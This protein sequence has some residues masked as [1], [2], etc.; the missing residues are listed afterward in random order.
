MNFMYNLVT[1]GKKII[2]YTVLIMLLCIILYY[3]D[4]YGSI[5]YEAYN[6]FSIFTQIITIALGF[7]L[8]LIALSSANMCNYNYFHFLAIIVGMIGVIDLF[9]ILIYKGANSL[10][11]D[12]NILFQ[13]NTLCRC[14][15]CIT[16]NLSIICYRKK[17]DFY[18]ILMINVAFVSLFLLSITVFKIFPAC[19]IEGYGL[20]SFVKVT[21]YLII[22]GFIIMLFQVNSSNAP[23]F[24]ENRE[25]IIK[26]VIF[27]VLESISF[28][29][30]ISTYS[31]AN[32]LGYVFKGLSC[33]FAFKLIFK[34]IMLNPYSILVQKLN[35]KVNELKT[36]N[37]ELLEAKYKI[38]SKENLHSR[39]INFIPDGV[40]IAR[41]KHIEFANDR[42]L[43]MLE[44][45]DINKILNRE[46]SEIID[47]KQREI[48]RARFN[49]VD[50]KILEIPQQYK[51]VFDGKEKWVEVTSIT[52]NDEKGE[53]IISTIRDI[54]DRKKAE[55]TERL[56]ELKKSEESMK[57][58][59]FCNISHEL[60]TPINVIYSA[61][62]V[63]NNALKNGESND[64][65]IKYNKIIRQNCLRLTR[66]VNNIID[67][68]K[69]ETGFFKPNYTIE[70]I[71]T[72]VEDITMSIIEYIESKNIKLI[73]DTEIEETYVECDSD[74]I[75]RIILNI[76]SNSVKYGRE[77]GT[78]KVSIYKKSSNAIEVSIKD[79]GIGIPSEMKDEIF[80]RFIK[81]DNSLSRKAEGSGMGLA[82]VKLLVELHKGNITLNSNVN[83]G[84]EFVIELPTVD[85][86]LEVCAARQKKVN[87]E[88]NITESVEM[89]FSDIYY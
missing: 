14:Y 52:V 12:Y 30:N 69:I 55:E 80:N 84:T 35:N 43:S 83:F 21:Q 89:E 47:D 16:I 9:Q 59:F 31:V 87:F 11:N 79:D 1:N 71:V 13:L 27:E 67:V 82:L 20:T 74:L 76:L 38:Q 75:E 62:Q 22:A 45:S 61:L 77:N 29:F 70:N 46:A 7:S 81:L 28:A 50:K 88:K 37:N 17:F 32:F 56:L 68:T 40:I 48:F 2:E 73:F 25:T 8:I 63:E 85:A 44:I 10:T 72:V 66:L 15:E 5:S 19:Y 49:N 26:I 57:N 58:E 3:I 86:S 53:Y 41:N 78:I 6:L 18:K 34:Y 64:F 54:E 60:R 33:Y 39:F 65:I 42:F 23:I 51:F 4:I 36:I 24:I